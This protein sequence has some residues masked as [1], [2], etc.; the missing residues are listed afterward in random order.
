[1]GTYTY[2]KGDF[3]GENLL[4]VHEALPFLVAY[5]N[6]VLERG[7]DADMAFDVKNQRVVVLCGGD[8]AMDCNRTS[9]RQSAD[10]VT[11]V[12]RRDDAIRRAQVRTPVTNAHIV[13]SILL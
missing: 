1:M 10:C 9:V 11:C 8:T 13:S 6:G 5:I 2:M 12:Y 4:G 7:N 3:P